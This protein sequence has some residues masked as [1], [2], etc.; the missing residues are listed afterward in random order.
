MNVA[1]LI[2]GVIARLEVIKGCVSEGSTALAIQELEAYLEHATATLPVQVYPRAGRT[3]AAS[4]HMD[5]DH[6]RSGDG[7]SGRTI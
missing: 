1:Q 2:V 4:D 7:G 6:H 5:Y 3:S